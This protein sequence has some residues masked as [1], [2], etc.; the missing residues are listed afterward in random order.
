[1][2]RAAAADGNRILGGLPAAE[3]KRIQAELTPVS[4]EIKTRLWNPNQPIE[5]V[6]FP[7]S[8]VA[9]VLAEVEDG[10]VEVGTVG[11]EGVVGLPVF[12][13]ARSF[14]GVALVQVAGDAYR[15]ESESFRRAAQDGQLHSLLQRYTLAFLTQ[16]S[17][18]TACNRSHSTE[19]RLAR[20]LL[21][22]R[23][24][25]GRNEF[26]LTHEFMGQMLGVRRATVT[27]TAQALQETGLIRYSRGTMT[28]TNPAGLQ[29]AACECYRI[30]KDEFE[31]LL[32]APVG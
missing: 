13:G 23:D 3:L 17:Q 6:Y 4:L 32:G 7:V 10:A 14:A 21:I 26:P 5:L 31:R 18:G 20:W 12:L 15:M 28:I 24:R 19:Q 11:N 1:M 22:M 16:V 25:V 27:E 9:S 8:M 2:A 29:R 30:V